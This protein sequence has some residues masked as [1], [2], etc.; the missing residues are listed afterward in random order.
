MYNIHKLVEF[1]FY[2]RIKRTVQNISSTD[3]SHV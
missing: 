3:I 2:V 1:P